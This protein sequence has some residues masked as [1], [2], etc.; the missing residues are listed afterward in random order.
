ML[1]KAPAVLL[2]ILFTIANS[3]FVYSAESNFWRDRQQLRP[4]SSAA[5]E[6]PLLAAL[7]AMAASPVRAVRDVMPAVQATVM[8][9]RAAAFR[10]TAV[11]DS[12][13]AILR[14]LPSRA[15]MIKDVYVHRGRSG[16]APFILIFQDI[17]QNAEAQRNLAA[18]FAAAADAAAAGGADSLVVGVEGA[19]GPFDF[20]PFRS[21]SDAALRTAVADA[22]LDDGR[23]AAPSYAGLTTDAP[24]AFV[25]VDDARH[26]KGNIRAYLDSQASRDAVKARLGRIDAGARAAQRDRLAPNLNAFLETRRSHDDGRLGFGDYV[27]RLATTVERVSPEAGRELV[28]DTFLRA[29]A[30]ER[31]LDF[32]RVERERDRVIM[33]LAEKISKADL[34]TLVTAGIGYRAG[35]MSYAGYH[36]QIKTL[37][38][39]YA[40]RLSDAPA[41]NAYLQYVLLADAIQ[42][43]ELLAAVARAEARVVGAL[44][45]GDGDRALVNAGRYAHLRARL[46]NFELIPSEWDAYRRLKNGEAP[47]AADAEPLPAGA[48]APFE[49]FY[50]EADRRSDGLVANLAGAIGQAPVGAL[51]VGGF[52]TPRLAALLR[53]K[54][55]SYAVV[56]PVVTKIDEDGG[57]YLSVFS[58]ETVPLDELFKGARLFLAPYHTA[59]GTVGRLPARTNASLTALLAWVNAYRGRPSA[60]SRA[61]VTIEGDGND[62]VAK[63]RNRHA[64]ARAARA[65]GDDGVTVADL[66]PVS[67]QATERE[68]DVG[69]AQGPPVMTLRSTRRFA[70]WLLTVLGLRVTEARIVGLAGVVEIPHSML[71]APIFP[72]FALLHENKTRSELWARIGLAGLLAIVTSGTFVAVYASFGSLGGALAAAAAVNGVV[73]VI[74]NELLLKLGILSPPSSPDDIAAETP[75]AP[76]TPVEESDRLADRSPDT[77]TDA[78]FEA[79]YRDV[80]EPLASILE[81]ADPDP[82]L[83]NA[84]TWQAFNA[85]IGQ[86]YDD[87]IAD[88]FDERLSAPRLTRGPRFASAD[89]GRAAM[90]AT[91]RAAADRLESRLDAA[92]ADKRAKPAAAIDGLRGVARSLDDGGANAQTLFYLIKASLFNRRV[93]RQALPLL[94]GPERQEYVVSVHNIGYYAD[95]KARFDG[96]RNRRTILARPGENGGFADEAEARALL[97]AD[98][99]RRYDERLRRVGTNDSLPKFT[100]VDFFEGDWARR[101]G[102]SDAEF[103]ARLE[104]QLGDVGADGVARARA[105][106]EGAGKDLDAPNEDLN[107]QSIAAFLARGEGESAAAYI[108]RLSGKQIFNAFAQDWQALLDQA[109]AMG[110]IARADALAGGAAEDA[111][112]AAARDAVVRQTEFIYRKQ[113]DA[114]TAQLIIMNT[115]S[116]FRRALDRGVDDPDVVERIDRAT[117]ALWRVTNPWF[118][119]DGGLIRAGYGGIGAADG[120]GVD[121]KIKDRTIWRAIINVRRTRHLIGRTNLD[122]ET[123][124]GPYLAAS[125]EVDDG[126]LA[127]G[128]NRLLRD[129]GETPRVQA[130]LNGLAGAADGLEDLSRRVHAMRHDPA[131]FAMATDAAEPGLIPIVVDG[132][133]GRRTYYLRATASLDEAGRVEILPAFVGA[134]NAA[135]RLYHAD[136]RRIETMLRLPK[137]ATYTLADGRI[138]A[139]AHNEAR[140][141]DTAQRLEDHAFIQSRMASVLPAEPV[142]VDSA[143]DVAGLLVAHP[144]GIRTIHQAIGDGDFALDDAF[145][146]ELVGLYVRG[147][148]FVDP[149]K[150]RAYGVLYEMG[151]DNFVVMPDGSVRHAYVDYALFYGTEGDRMEHGFFTGGYGAAANWILGDFAPL[152]RDQIDLVWMGANLSADQRRRRDLFVSA[153]SDALDANLSPAVRSA[154]TR[155]YAYVQRLVDFGS[156]RD[157]VEAYRRLTRADHDVSRMYAPAV[158]AELEASA[159]KQKA[160]DDR[161]NAVRKDVDRLDAL[162]SDPADFEALDGGQLAAIFLAYR[163]LENFAGMQRL[164]ESA[165]DATERDPRKR[166]FVEA[167]NVVEFYAVALNK[168][169]EKAIK[170]LR[171]LGQTDSLADDQRAALAARDW[172]AVFD[173]MSQVMAA[174]RK[175]IDRGYGNGELYGALGKAWK[176]VVSIIDAA[177]Q[178]ENLE[179]AAIARRGVNRVAPSAGD[180]TLAAR[181]RA[182]LERQFEAYHDGFL[183]NFDFYPGINAVYALIELGRFDEALI[184]ADLTYSTIEQMGGK[185]SNNVWALSTLL[186][187]AV[188]RAGS[189]RTVPRRLKDGRVVSVDAAAAEMVDIVRRHR[190][191]T[192]NNEFDAYAVGELESRYKSFL[193]ASLDAPGDRATLIWVIEQLE[194]IPNEPITPTTPLKRSDTVNDWIFHLQNYNDQS[195][196]RVVTGNFRFGGQLEDLILGRESIRFAQAFL[197]ENPIDLLDR[198]LAEID[199]SIERTR[200]RERDASGDDLTRIGQRRRALLLLARQA[201]EARDGLEGLGAPSFEDVTSLDELDA[202]INVFLRYQFGT[203]TLEDLHSIEHAVFDRAVQMLNQISGAR[204]T[205]DSA[206]DPVADMLLGLGD[207]RHHAFLKQA[208]FDVWKSNRMTRLM[209]RIYEMRKSGRPA[210]ETEAAQTELTSLMNTQMYV[211][212]GMVRAQFSVPALYE[213]ERV[214]GELVKTERFN[215]VE[216]HTLNMVVVFEDGVVNGAPARIVSN[217]YFADAFYQGQG[218]EQTEYRWGRYEIEGVKGLTEP[219]FVKALGAPNFLIADFQNG[220]SGGTVADREIAVL[221]HLKKIVFALATNP[222]NAG[223]VDRLPETF[224]DMIE[225]AKTAE[226]DGDVVLLEPDVLEWERAFNGILTQPDLFA[227]VERDP[228]LD[229]AAATGKRKETVSHAN[230]MLATLGWLRG[231]KVDELGLF[232][233]RNVPILNRAIFDA[234]FFGLIRPKSLGL[235]AGRATVAE[236]AGDALVRDDAGDIVRSDAAIVI[237][238]DWYA[239]T[240]DQNYDKYYDQFLLRG[241]QVERPVIDEIFALSEKRENVRRALVSFGAERDAEAALLGSLGPVL[242]SEL[243]TSLRADHGVITEDPLVDVAATAM[244]LERLGVDDAYDRFQ[245]L[246]GAL[247]AQPDAA[248]AARALRDVLADMEPGTGVAAGLIETYAT[249]TA[250]RPASILEPLFRDLFFTV[251]WLYVLLT[252]VVVPLAETGLF[253]ALPGEALFAAGVLGV[254]VLLLIAVPIAALFAVAHPLFAAWRAGQI[255]SVADAARV[256]RAIAA[257]PAARTPV[258]R[259]FGFGYGFTALYFVLGSLGLSGLPALLAVSAAHGAFNLGATLARIRRLRQIDGLVAEIDAQGPDGEPT[260]AQL[261]RFDA[262]VLAPLANLY[263]SETTIRDGLNA[264]TWT[265]YLAVRDGNEPELSPRVNRWTLALLA[266][267]HRVRTAVGD[268]FEAR[269]KRDGKSQHLLAMAEATHTSYFNENDRPRIGV[270]R[271]DADE[272]TAVFL[273]GDFG[274]LSPEDRAGLTPAE[275]RAR[276]EAFERRYI[277][278]EAYLNRFDNPATK[279]KLTLNDLVADRARRLAFLNHVLAAN[280]VATPLTEADL[281]RLEENPNQQ[282]INTMAQPWESLRLE[283]RLYSDSDAREAWLFKQQRQAVVDAYL[284]S[285]LE[286]TKRV[287]AGTPFWRH[288]IYQRMNVFWRMYDWHGFDD[289]LISRPYLPEAAESVAVPAENGIGTYQ[290]K[291][292]RDIF[293]QI[294]S[295]IEL[296]RIETAHEAD[297]ET[298][299]RREAWKAAA[300]DAA[301]PDAERR[302]AAVAFLDSYGLILEGGALD[303][304]RFEREHLVPLIAAKGKY[305]RWTRPYFEAT[306]DVSRYAQL[307]EEFDLS[308]EEKDRLAPITHDQGYWAPLKNGELVSDSPLGKRRNPAS[309][310]L[311]ATLSNID[312]DEELSQEA[313]AALLTPEGL[314]AYNARYAE[315]KSKKFKLND[316]VSFKNR[317]AFFAALGKTGIAGENLENPAWNPEVLNTL[318]APW[319]ALQAR[320]EALGARADEQRAFLLSKQTAAIAQVKLSLKVMKRRVLERLGWQIEL[321]AM[322]AAQGLS[323]EEVLDVLIEHALWVTNPSAQWGGK[324]GWENEYDRKM[325]ALVQATTDI[326]AGIEKGNFATLEDALAIFDGEFTKDLTIVNAIRGALNPRRSTLQRL[327]GALRPFAP[328]AVIAPGAGVSGTLPSTVTAVVRFLARFGF[329]VTEPRVRA[330]AGLYEI[331]RVFRG[332]FENDH[333]ENGA[334]ADT[335]RNRRIVRLI[336]WSTRIGTFAFPL[337]LAFALTMGTGL[338]VP[339]VVAAVIASAPVANVA[340]HAGWN[341]AL[342]YLAGERLFRP[343]ELEILQAV[344]RV[345]GRDGVD[346]A[347]LRA[348]LAVPPVLNLG[349]GERTVDPNR[350]TVETRILEQIENGV[351]DLADLLPTLALLRSLEAAPVQ[352]RSEAVAADMP[353]GAAGLLIGLNSGESIEARVAALAADRRASDWILLE[354]ADDADVDELSRRYAGRRIAFAR[355]SELNLTPDGLRAVMGGASL[356][357]V[358][359]FVDEAAQYGLAPAVVDA[360]SA[361]EANRAVLPVDIYLM[362]TTLDAAMA[363]KVSVSDLVQAALMRERLIAIQA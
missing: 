252:A 149:S 166:D 239:G 83:W 127:D 119:F 334:I 30:L 319:D 43:D 205:G 363:V 236:R 191:A 251:R 194:S 302:A 38:E 259:L 201:R 184:L 115:P 156:R 25:G 87:E 329:R 347:Q 245:I 171:K 286:S 234:L 46:I 186:Q 135:Y 188:I 1:R 343:A 218:A 274:I 102:E 243:M 202:A 125:R 229:E 281:A 203:Q 117:N 197:D 120:I 6:G 3:A 312:S 214:D 80:V 292:D 261:E 216:A 179:V 350:E 348:L 159:Q 352:S 2:A 321:G 175:L 249:P 134:T 231:K 161:F 200:E 173:S 235:D 313:L 207:C 8:A 42:P 296:F 86:S 81:P 63:A 316:L 167:S 244:D 247:I 331:V 278:N 353:A 121:Q 26:Y 93:A 324:A 187:L 13:E 192:Q 215:D 211:L 272:T 293:N 178:S 230:R 32:E 79:A 220:A 305:G 82:A 137:G 91:F 113:I 66:P 76:E 260:P 262:L 110:E 28:V 24:L 154:L 23:I 59:A 294:Y 237:A 349:V 277:A 157:G 341:F 170:E 16:E 241:A 345:T 354:V 222:D 180:G 74:S 332:T 257:N 339:A 143:G 71:L 309:P 128:I 97:S 35:D 232:E 263:Q 242:A 37:L 162:W 41:F 136:G 68:G 298:R 182:A 27:A 146:G 267:A 307:V 338:P 75:E 358:K 226:S 114:L 248:V 129:A 284:I 359:V 142:R 69:D 100:M 204:T 109:A 326:L 90:A 340:V 283:A 36:A 141:A 107:A 271:N 99:R 55:F 130:A 315:V 210:A 103:E 336:A 327:T 131:L 112:D 322:M 58:R 344:Q 123:A 240:R 318:A 34:E 172:E 29:H 253:A 357:R 250:A 304:E 273:G 105:F 20:S 275:A 12:A 148:G 33:R 300:D 256:L 199:D 54:G 122:Y 150:G 163:S 238:A 360:L 317:A 78:E 195:T 108:Q 7:P 96:E 233:K 320:A 94:S 276:I 342:Y 246:V 70:T 311:G 258:L 299:E 297:P 17:H 174:T 328:A 333:F 285:Q 18:L 133:E 21:F 301:R 95:Q 223:I 362:V 140:Y 48:L 264:E 351:D 310:F 325:E 51:V 160:F 206:T 138:G 14:A 295:N 104:V 265:A 282:I 306:Y 221:R 56:Q 10:G 266:A 337:G 198:L 346:R 290:I 124:F 45:R 31:A 335:P 225:A 145:V 147:T 151:P 15:G 4:A 88:L 73:H 152:S 190:A 40:V 270:A 314:A 85:Y 224:R 67:I 308:A 165:A 254:G 196:A 5:G 50:E 11:P 126:G 176:N 72:V 19:F 49:A 77:I 144:N 193:E 303:I 212:D 153:L 279:F 361:L 101:E 62:L 208:I 132:P 185:F 287:A 269:L 291:K 155:E 84:A 118:G 64:T 106:L 217:A 92:P 57:A 47:L 53:K 268:R 181:R 189:G 356:R 52:H 177:S 209:S 89:A 61:D 323:L 168:Q 60:A 227:G 9:E 65:T 330:L 139:S 255:K 116:L 44:A 280:G 355:S 213:P 158:A 169:A 288:P 98:A 22:F 183:L 289:A 39:R 111:A 228:R 219:A 164:F